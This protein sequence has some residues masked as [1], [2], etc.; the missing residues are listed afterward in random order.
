MWKTYV[1]CSYFLMIWYAIRCTLEYYYS[2]STSVFFQSNFSASVATFQL[3]V[4]WFI[5]FYLF[6][7]EFNSF[8]NENLEFNSCQLGLL[9][10]H[11]LPYTGLPFVLHFCSS[12]SIQQANPESNILCKVVTD[13]VI[14]DYLHLETCFAHFWLS[15]LYFFHWHYSY[16]WFEGLQLVHYSG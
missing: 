1:W 5:C 14:V 2:I 4:K 6:Y 10:W 7:P 8:L 11:M 9:C 16:F 13:W 3:N 15:T 12:C